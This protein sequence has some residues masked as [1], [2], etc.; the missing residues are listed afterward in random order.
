[1]STEHLKA[2]TK[3]FFD[4]F[5]VS[6]QPVKMLAFFSTQSPV[7]LQHAP[8]ECPHPQTSRL[9]G[10]NAIRSYFD[11]LATHWTRSDVKLR[12]APEIDAENRRVVVPASVVWKWRRSGRQFRE[13]FTWT[14]EF[15]DNMKITSFVVKTI[16]G[17]C[18]MRATDTA[19]TESPHLT[20]A[21]VSH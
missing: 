9:D 16:S 15:D 11:I 12:Q 13:I 19:D 18:V 4:A 21:S 7:I 17:T 2:S 1:M 8:I 3:A 20:H 6:T 14:L 10:S 5:A